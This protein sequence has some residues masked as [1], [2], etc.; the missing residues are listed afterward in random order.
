[1]GNG[2]TP[3]SHTKSSHSATAMTASMAAVICT[4]AKALL[5]L[6]GVQG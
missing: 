6:V 2:I 3:L 5:S 1:M 4:L